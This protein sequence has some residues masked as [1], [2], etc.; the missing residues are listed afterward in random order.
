[1]MRPRIFLAALSALA[2]AGCGATTAPAPPV[3]HTPPPAPEPAKIAAYTDPTPHGSIAARVVCE[4][5]AEE[6]TW[7]DFVIPG[8][9]KRSR[10]LCTISSE[11]LDC[12]KGERVTRR[13]CSEEPLGP[14]PEVSRGS[15]ILRQTI[16]VNAWAEL[17]DAAAPTIAGHIHMYTAF[18]TPGACLA[19]IEARTNS[20]RM[21]M[22]ASDV[23]FS[24]FPPG[25]AQSGAR[26]PAW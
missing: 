7:T 15:T 3:A 19:R 1:M 16:D 20:P 9:D 26:S 17:M 10:D 11:R 6:A 2:S 5:P 12:P 22:L 8:T 13:T 18:A 25:G 14:A 21:A 4:S 23:S 24:C